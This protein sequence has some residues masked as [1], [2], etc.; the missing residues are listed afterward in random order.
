MSR[1]IDYYF[2][3]ISPWAYIGHAHL[4]AVAARHGAVVQYWPVK[5]LEVFSDSGGMPLPKRH[6]LRQRYRTVELQRWRDHR[7]LDFH[8][9]P[10]FWP[11]DASLADRVV[12]ALVERDAD[13]ETFLPLAYAAVWERQKDLADRAVLSDLLRRSGHD[14]AVVLE[15]AERDEI[16]AQLQANGHQALAAGVFG[17]PSYVL[18]G[19]V[20][21]GQD[22]LDLLDEALETGRSPYGPHARLT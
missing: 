18:D 7:G 17:S 11:F 13:V 9:E 14:P 20:F 4:A 19:E 15:L 22:R 10:A 16:A 21:W 5:L 8:L 12:I 1:R 6:P 3:L 2:S